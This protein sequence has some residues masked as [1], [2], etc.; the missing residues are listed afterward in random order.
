MRQNLVVNGGFETQDFSGWLQTNNFSFSGVRPGVGS[1]PEGLVPATFLQADG[2]RRCRRDR[3][4]LNAEVLGPVVTVQ[5]FA[6][7]NE[8]IARANDVNYGLAA[9]VWT[10]PC[11]PRASRK[12][13]FGTVWMT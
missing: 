11:W 5:R 13:Q 12:L 2:G 4:C 10:S 8:A 6:D 1:V 3:R 7:D 9:S